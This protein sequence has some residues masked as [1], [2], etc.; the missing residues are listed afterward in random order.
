MPTPRENGNEEQDR[1][2]DDLAGA[3]TPCVAGEYRSA[4]NTLFDTLGETQNWYVF[5]NASRSF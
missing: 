1:D 4:V 2:D 5:C 3:G